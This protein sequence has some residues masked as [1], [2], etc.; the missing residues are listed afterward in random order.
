MGK[1][2]GLNRRRFPR[3]SYPCLVVIRND[4]PGKKE[5]ILTHTENV[6]IGGVCVILKQNINVF[7]PVE[8]EL[9]LLD[10]REHIKCKGKIVWNIQRKPD[11]PKKP[12]FY[13]VGIEFQNLHRK[14]LLRLEEVITRLARDDKEI[15]KFP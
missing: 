2:E 8:I 11:A 5:A 14:D 1:W 9:D 12:L 3:V 6:G 13:D 15:S 10:L 7:Y 4:E